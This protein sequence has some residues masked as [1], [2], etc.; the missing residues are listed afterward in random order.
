MR[1]T[2][3]RPSNCAAAA[4]AVSFL[5]AGAYQ[6]AVQGLAIKPRNADL[7]FYK[8]W[9]YKVTAAWPW[10]CKACCAA[11]MLYVVQHTKTIKQ[12]VVHTAFIVAYVLPSW[13]V[14][15]TLHR[16]HYA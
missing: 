2:H 15:A 16:T 12:P 13:Y 6:A 14:V 4:A 11:F 10:R 8:A 1:A 5:A 7:L 3:P 9:A